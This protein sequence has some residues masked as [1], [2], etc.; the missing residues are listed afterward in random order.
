MTV[1]A[2]HTW[3]RITTRLDFIKLSIRDHDAV[4]EGNRS[5]Q[6]CIIAVNFDSRIEPGVLSKD[7]CEPA[8]NRLS[9]LHAMFD[10]LAVRNASMLVV[11]VAAG[12]ARETQ[13]VR[14]SFT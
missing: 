10:S 13:C 5:I 4:L 11:A 6:S 3:T 1:M 14:R 2:V 7:Y 12:P 9:H 8:G